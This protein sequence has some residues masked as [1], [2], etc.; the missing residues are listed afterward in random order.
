MALSCP[1]FYSHFPDARR[2]GYAKVLHDFRE[3]I[4]NHPDAC[5]A[6][7]IQELAEHF[8]NIQKDYE[9]AMIVRMFLSLYRKDTE[10]LERDLLKIEKLGAAGTAPN[11]RMDLLCFLCRRFCSFRTL[12]IPST[13][14]RGVTAGA[15]TDPTEFEKILSEYKK[16]V[17]RDPDADYEPYTQKLEALVGTMRK[18]CAER[19]LTVILLNLYPTDA[20]LL[21]QDVAKAMVYSAGKAASLPFGTDRRVLLQCLCDALSSYIGEDFSLIIENAQDES[22]YLR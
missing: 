14:A 18:A 17:C 2:E 21:G 16:D 8:N 1:I 7:F 5:F 10:L 9:S 22:G 3:E 15:L 13:A 12:N 20:Q 19:I 6:P 11:E 4:H